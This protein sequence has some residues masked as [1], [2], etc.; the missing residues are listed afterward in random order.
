MLPSRLSHN[1][2]DKLAKVRGRV[3]RSM[4]VRHPGTGHKLTP[5]SAAREL[6]PYEEKF[7]ERARTELR[8]EHGVTD[9]VRFDSWV[10][11]QHQVFPKK[12]AEL[13]PHLRAAVKF[14]GLNITESAEKLKNEFM[15]NKREAADAKTVLEKQLETQIAGQSKYDTKQQQM[16]AMAK[17]RLPLPSMVGRPHVSEKMV[18]AEERLASLYAGLSQR[19]DDT[20]E[21]LKKAVLSNGSDRDVFK[22]ALVQRYEYLASWSEGTRLENAGNQ[23]RL[24]E[25]NA[26][27]ISCGK[28]PQTY[29]DPERESRDISLD[30]A[31]VARCVLA[32]VPTDG[33]WPIIIPHGRRHAFTVLQ[34]STVEDITAVLSFR[35]RGK[36]GTA[37][38]K[39]QG[40]ESARDAW[41]THLSGD[42][43]GGVNDVKEWRKKNPW[44]WKDES[45]PKSYVFR[46]PTSHASPFEQ[47]SD[48]V[49]AEGATGLR[50]LMETKT[51]ADKDV[52]RLDSEW[53]KYKFELNKKYNSKGPNTHYRARHGG[54][55]LP[56][57]IVKSAEYGDR[58]PY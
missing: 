8:E 13:P 43:T 38:R 45:E 28:D 1:M 6:T 44:D 51:T 32:D 49:G 12:V 29:H 3:D 19:R 40:F 7:A 22:Q 30:M 58:S 14:G 42:E 20:R 21:A 35:D 15:H 27:L 57:R 10:S 34:R 4:N 53:G 18:K 37:L 52:S 56:A 39:R 24:D 9:Q 11:Q 5:P 36:L 47:I 55:P 26:S 54:N 17:S 46:D 23:T 31:G 33:T 16:Q 25:L 50:A 48:R 41:R 2:Y